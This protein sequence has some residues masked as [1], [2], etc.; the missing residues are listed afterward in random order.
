M[1]EAVGN[2]RAREYWRNHSNASP[3]RHTSIA[4]ETVH[5]PIGTIAQPQVL[6]FL[7]PGCRTDTVATASIPIPF[8]ARRVTRL[9]GQTRGSH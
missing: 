4:T 7:P 2:Q 3:S 1:M 5:A 8:P 6:C 9:T